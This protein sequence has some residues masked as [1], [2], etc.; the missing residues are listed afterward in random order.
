[1][2]N[3]SYFYN[4]ETLI[5]FWIIFVLPPCIL[6]NFIPF[7]MKE[8]IPTAMS[9]SIHSPMMMF[10]AHAI[11]CRIR[12]KTSVIFHLITSIISITT[13]CIY[14]AEASRI[15]FGTSYTF[16]ALASVSGQDSLIITTESNS[17]EGEIYIGAWLANLI[18][19]GFLLFASMI[20]LLLSILSLMSMDE[21]QEHSFFFKNGNIYRHSVTFFSITL[22]IMVFAQLIFSYYLLGQSAII[23]N[24]VENYSGMMAYLSTACILLPLPKKQGKKSNETENERMLQK[25]NNNANIAT[26]F[27]ASALILQCSFLIVGLA[28]Q[29]SWLQNNNI[30]WACDLKGIENKLL[31]NTAFDYNDF[32]NIQS[33]LYS[34]D[35][36]T[37]ISI[38]TIAV[39]TCVDMSFSIVFILLLVLLC[40]FSIL[41]LYSMINGHVKNVFDHT[42]TKY[43]E[44]KN[45]P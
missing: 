11:C 17:P 3:S 36:V 20:H 23:L 27:L 14:F 45:Y 22:F 41:Y 15:K 31:A 16:S 25:E 19:I 42:A 34:N 39:F 43:Q 44:I 35:T 5:I 32:T 33:L 30:N 18:F 26:G 29:S 7:W 9:Y 28:T 10:G 24:P 4:Y 21:D 2:D 1:M 12:N 13:L 38:S 6:L 8:F 37:P 40:I